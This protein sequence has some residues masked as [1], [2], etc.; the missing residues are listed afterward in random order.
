V[1]LGLKVTMASWLMALIIFAVV[2]GFCVLSCCIYKCCLSDSSTARDIAKKQA[3]MAQYHKNRQDPAALER[4]RLMMAQPW[5][6]GD[7]TPTQHLQPP[8]PGEETSSLYSRS[9]TSPYYYPTSIPGT[10][11]PHVYIGNQRMT[12]LQAKYALAMTKIQ[13]D[14]DRK[15][16][17]ADAKAAARAAPKPSTPPI[18]AE[19][20]LKSVQEAVEPRAPDVAPEPDVIV[21]DESESELEAQQSVAE[22]MAAVEIEPEPKDQQPDQEYTLDNI[23]RVEVAKSHPECQALALQCLSRRYLESLPDA[24]CDRLIECC[25][26]A[27]ES[28]ERDFVGCVAHQAEDYATFSA[29]FA[30]V[31]DRVAPPGPTA[32]D[33]AMSSRLFRSEVTATIEAH[34]SVEGYLLPPAMTVAARVD[35]E[36][37]LAGFFTRLKSSCEVTAHGS[38]RSFTVGHPTEASPEER[39][40]I[41]GWLLTEDEAAGARD[42][43]EWLQGKG[44]FLSANG[45]PMIF[46]GFRGEH[47]T[48]HFEHT[49]RQ[50]SEAFH[51]ADIVLDAAAKDERVKLVTSDGFGWITSHPEYAGVGTSQATIKTTL[52]DAVRP[53]QVNALVDSIGIT[54]TAE[55]SFGGTTIWELSPTMVCGVPHNVMLPKLAASVVILEEEEYKALNDGTGGEEYELDLGTTDTAAIAPVTRAS[56]WGRDETNNWPMPPSTATL[57][58][59]DQLE[60]LAVAPDVVQEPAPTLLTSLLAEEDDSLPPTPA[61]ASAARAQFSNGLS[62][63]QRGDDSSDD[64]LNGAPALFGASSSSKSPRKTKR[65][66][67]EETNDVNALL[68][69][70][71]APGRLRS[72]LSQQPSAR[73]EPQKAATAEESNEQCTYLGTCKCPKC[74]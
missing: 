38:Y 5:V 61:V 54:A 10:P 63:S 47:L 52:I 4:Q 18:K 36:E 34:R 37:H 55:S 28:P 13:L 32:I 51:F 33:E 11:G 68:S 16:A 71:V 45:I 39:T 57:D 58:G 31:R 48:F 25:A 70:M 44:C 12:G 59:G 14:H 50:L 2:I 35:L 56:R 66:S 46:V 21:V 67:V 15:V 60:P 42:D 20:V 24:E 8:L 73:D 40:E 19:P 23:A 49:S 74:R 64:D 22:G 72:K 43:P 62:T 53:E 9:T 6:H 26:A 7:S 17:K 29:F 69:S 65:P 3:I 27:L 41:L 1:N 30:E